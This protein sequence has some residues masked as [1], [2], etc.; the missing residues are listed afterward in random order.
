MQL[1]TNGAPRAR[2]E[3]LVVHELPD[4]LLIYDLDRHRSHCLSRTAALVWRQC[5]GQTSVEEMAAILERD[6]EL[7]ADPE[8]VWLVLERLDRARL[9]AERLDLPVSP[10]G[11]SRRKLLRQLAVWGGVALVTSIVAPEAAYALTCITEV[12]PGRC[13]QTSACGDPC[14]GTGE[15]CNGSKR[16]GKNITGNPPTRP[17]ATAVQC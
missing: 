15:P 13:P 16:C 14:R 10:A 8:M 11:S 6:L 12:S 7:A 4:E 1:S 3:G 5:D 2:N 9:L 17:C